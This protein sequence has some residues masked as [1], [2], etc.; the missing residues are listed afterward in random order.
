[1]IYCLAKEIP[2]T[3]IVKYEFKNLLTDVRS[4]QINHME[5]VTVYD[6]RNANSLFHFRITTTTT[7]TTATTTTTTATTTICTTRTD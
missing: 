7:T 5:E 1:M 6:D 2:Y 4:E 3:Y